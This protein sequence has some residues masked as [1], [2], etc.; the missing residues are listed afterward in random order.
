MRLGALDEA[1]GIARREA[2]AT[3]GE[4]AVADD[5]NAAELSVLGRNT[6]CRFCDHCRLRQ[7]ARHE[8]DLRCLVQPLEEIGRETTRL[9]CVAPLAITVVTEQPAGERIGFDF[10]RALGRIRAGQTLLRV[11]R[12]RVGQQQSR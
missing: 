5:G 11:P 8:P 6:S 1:E 2:Q 4:G 9:Q 7:L 10:R 12:R 3:G